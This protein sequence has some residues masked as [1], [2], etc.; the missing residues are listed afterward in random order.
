MTAMS[1]QL[2][3]GVTTGSVSRCWSAGP[4]GAV[5]P[6]D[7]HGRVHPPGSPVAVGPA[8][9]GPDV[10]QAAVDGLAALVAG[11]TEVAAG[12]GVDLGGGF[13]SARLA[14]APG[15]RRDALL[16]ALRFLGA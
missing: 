5:V 11:G 1:V 3:F 15:D 8:G 14:G 4:G 12:A 16:A 7:D 2:A 13:S 6:V 9:A 10:V